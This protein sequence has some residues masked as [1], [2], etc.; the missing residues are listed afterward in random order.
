MGDV[1]E[2]YGNLGG[3]CCVFFWNFMDARME[4]ILFYVQWWI[5]KCYINFIF[6][7]YYYYLKYALLR[8]ASSEDVGDLWLVPNDRKAPNK[9]DLKFGLRETRKV[10]LSLSVDSQG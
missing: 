6:C 8:F 7:C 4:A 1:V 2:C 9:A 10:W 5:V 3:V